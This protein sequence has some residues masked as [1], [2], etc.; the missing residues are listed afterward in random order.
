MKLVWA[1]AAWA[2]YLYWLE[3]DR[4]IIKRINKIIEDIKQNPFQGIGNPEPL[5]YNW[6]GY[7]SRRITREHRLVYKPEGDRLF[8]AQCRYHY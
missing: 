4:K 5:R 1:D 6:Q 8:I 2:D 3:T 7:W